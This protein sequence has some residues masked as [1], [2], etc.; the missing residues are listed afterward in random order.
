MPDLSMA[1]IAVLGVAALVAST[2]AG[3]TGF[4]GAAVLLPLLVLVFGPRNAVPI[5]TV[6]QLIGNGSRV[7]LNRAAVD[8]RVVG[9]Y[10]VGA[11]PLGLLGGLLFAR[12]PAATLTRLLGLVLI[13]MVG[14]RH[15][16]SASFPKPTLHG[17]ALIGAAASLLSALVGS[18]G[19]LM[20]PLFLAYGLVK[21]A[22]IG[23]EAMA[24]VVTHVAKLV[25][26]Q[27]TA[28]LST[29]ASVVGLGLGPVM[30]AGSYV[31]KRI[32]DRMPERVFVL[33]IEATMLGAGLLFMIRG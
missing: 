15:L 19:P 31:G 28:V 7:L 29:S 3:V 5:L 11:V 17:F 4:G 21:G 33:L 26:Y 27:G 18:V 9:W 23:T 8:H 16:R 6:A 10:S 14:W 13:V 12:A 32:V 2:L 24:T 22:Y 30:V 25:A 20:A 1:Q